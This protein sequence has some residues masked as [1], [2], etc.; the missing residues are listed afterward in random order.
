MLSCL[1]RSA[2]DES[3][4]AH[5]RQPRP[6]S[7]AIDRVRLRDD[8]RPRISQ[9]WQSTATA[10]SAVA[11]ASPPPAYLECTASPPA[12]ATASTEDKGDGHWDAW[13]R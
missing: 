2:G 7:T 6:E 12:A 5:A 11:R 10:L 3:C 4:H 8:D 13:L 9:Q 1:A